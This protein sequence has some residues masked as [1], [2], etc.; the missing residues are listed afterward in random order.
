M[1]LALVSTPPPPLYLHAE[2]KAFFKEDV[3]DIFLF[4]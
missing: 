1:G 4:V 3:F 2:K